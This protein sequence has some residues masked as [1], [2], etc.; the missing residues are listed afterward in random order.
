ML[1][2]ETEAEAIH[3]DM[4]RVT[5]RDIVRTSNRVTAD[6]TASRED[7]PR[8]AIPADTAA[9]GAALVLSAGL[10]ALADSG[11]LIPVQ[12]NPRD[13]EMTIFP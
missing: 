11:V 4:V 8:V 10:V 7:I 9:G 2:T 3:K 6:P 12:V 1:P 13:G 5:D